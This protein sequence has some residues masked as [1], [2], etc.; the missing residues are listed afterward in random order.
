MQNSAQPRPRRWSIFFPGAVLWEIAAWTRRRQQP[1]PR[2]ARRGLLEVV[3]PQGSDGFVLGG[4]TPLELG[5]RG[6]ARFGAA[7]VCKGTAPCGRTRGQAARLGVVLSWHRKRTP[8]AV[9]AKGILLYKLREAQK[10][11]HGGSP[12]SFWKFEAARLANRT[13]R[14]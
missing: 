2:P 1:G 4:Q 5:Q 9:G 8:W 14:C 10:E 12:D 6:Q 7:N 3:I 13:R 11:A